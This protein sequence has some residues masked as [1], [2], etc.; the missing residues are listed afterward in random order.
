MF[1]TYADIGGPAEGQARAKKLRVELGKRGLDG[2]IVP[3]ADE[4]Q[5]EYLPPSAERLAWLTGF[6]GSAGTAIVLMDEAYL[7]IDGRYKIQARQQ[8]DLDIFTPK[9]LIDDPPPKW[10]AD[11]LPDGAKLGYD[12][13]LHTIDGAKAL[14]AACE[15]AGGEL[16]AVEDNPL[17]AVWLD[18]PAPPSGCVVAH[19]IAFAGESAQAKL[20]R[21]GKKLGKN[22]CDALILTVADS[23]AWTFNIRGQDVAHNPVALCYAVVRKSGKATLLIDPRKI[24]DAARKHLEPLCEIVDQ[25][26]LGP[27]LDGLRQDDIT[28]QLDPASAADWFSRALDGGEAEV[29]HERD[30]VILMKAVKNDAEIAGMRA[31]HLRD[32]VAM[33]RFLHWLDEQAGSGELDEI[34]A[35]KKLEE[36]RVSSNKLKEI[37]FDSISASGP[38]GAMCHYRVNETSN[39][40]I[41]PDSLYLIDSGGQ[42]EDGTTDITRTIAI[43]K[44]T[45]EMRTRFT[46]VLKGHIAIA[47]A[48]FPKGTSG[49]QIDAFARRHLWDAGLDFEH[50]T[51]H[52][53]GA[54]LAVHEGPQNIS[55]RGVTALE[56]GMIVSNE[57]GY[58]KEGE[59]GIRIENLVLVTEPVEGPDGLEFLSFETLS[60]TPI[61]L[62]LVDP[63][64]MSEDEIAWLNAYHAE[65]RDK[66][67]PLVKD[68]DKAW[69]D[70]A[71]RAISR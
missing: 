30:P 10:L 55:K 29:K 28:I 6:T 44:P 39:R 52:G 25:D 50:G 32:G 16:V 46:L 26:Q 23:I 37:S 12:P 61:D 70:Q 62:R 21:I 5:S 19:D 3:H 15:K 36:I 1:Q 49:A 59:Y 53:V 63:A 38:N 66:L 69:L 13:R 71:T 65:T 45:A 34:S 57:P 18:R 41:E 64:I 48:R 27:V 40:R 9:S 22:N 4:Y 33:C 60:F 11:H 43:G 17:D 51:G 20:A 8:A 31:A 56:P 42:Y 54:Y 35:A 24:D 58:Y 47:T 68:E 7:F 14:R 67:I 2:F